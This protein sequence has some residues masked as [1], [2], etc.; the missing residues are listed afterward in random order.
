[1]TFWIPADQISPAVWISVYML[2]PIVF[3]FFNVRRYGEIEFWLTTAKVITCMGLIVLGILL[4]MGASTTP[5]LLGTSPKYDLIQC[6]NATVDNCVSPPGFVC[7]F[8]N[9]STYLFLQIGEKMGWKSSW[10]GEIGAA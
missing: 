4:P 5:R 6:V 7:T 3:N 1:M 9:I 2:F 8:S 10:L